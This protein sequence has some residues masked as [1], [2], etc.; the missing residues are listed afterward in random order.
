MSKRQEASALPYATTKP[1]GGTATVG[2]LALDLTTTGKLPRSRTVSGSC[3]ILGEKVVGRSGR[4]FRGRL[5]SYMPPVDTT[6]R[7]RLLE[8]LEPMFEWF[9]HGVVVGVVVEGVVVLEL[10]GVVVVLVEAAPD[11][12]VP[13]PSP[14]PRVLPAM[15]APNRNFLRDD[16]TMCSFGVVRPP[17]EGLWRDLVGRICSTPTLE[18]T[19]VRPS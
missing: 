14:S 7:S 13:R 18:H 4:P 16:A 6:T 12:T 11:I 8:E 2:N 10:A 1:A 17:T 15:P 19:N 9:G 3:L 5:S